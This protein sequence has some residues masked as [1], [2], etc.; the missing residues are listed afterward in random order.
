MNWPCF[1][2]GVLVTKKLWRSGSSLHWKFVC[3]SCRFCSTG[4]YSEYISSFNLRHS[5]LFCTFHYPQ[6]V[7]IIMR[8]VEW[9]VILEYTPVEQKGH[10]KHENDQWRLLS[11]KFVKYILTFLQSHVPLSEA[12]CQFV[13]KSRLSGRSSRRDVEFKLKLEF[14][15]ESDHRP[16]DVIKRGWRWNSSRSAWNRSGL[17]QSTTWKNTKWFG[18]HS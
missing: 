1:G 7:R 13:N 4:V 10:K 18:N 9:G 15:F 17:S 11:C 12:N 2:V 5:Y 8:Y 3:Y 16:C 14:N 6:K